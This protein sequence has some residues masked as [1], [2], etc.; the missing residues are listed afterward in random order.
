MVIDTPRRQQGDLEEPEQVQVATKKSKQSTKL[1]RQDSSTQQNNQGSLAAGTTQSASERSKAVKQLS[2][3]IDENTHHRISLAT[4]RAGKASINAWMEEVLS[5]AADDILES[6]KDVVISET[7]QTLL[8]D[9][10][11]ATRLI[12]GV[13]P[14]LRDSNPPTVFQFSHALKKLLIGWDMMKPFVEAASTELTP[15][16]TQG[17]SKSS[18][19]VTKLVAA[20][21]PFLQAT[22]AVSVLRYDAAL[23]KLLL[24]LAAVSPFVKEK[25]IDSLLQIAVVVESLLEEIQP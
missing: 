1:D 22:D 24:G 12:E 6:S 4:Q 13:T 5:A 2:L 14:Y 3:R 8:E 17:L 19:S 25:K 9:P 10:C 15:E 7:I 20:V 16:R 21:I 18:Q 11:Y 23:K